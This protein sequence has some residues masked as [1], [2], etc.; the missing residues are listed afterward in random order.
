[1][2]PNAVFSSTIPGGSAVT[3]PMTAACAPSGWA[4]S[5]ASAVVGLVRRRPRRPAGP[6]R[7]RT[8]GRCRAV[9]RRRGPS[10]ATGMA[11]SLTSTPTPAEVGHLV[12]DGGHPAAGGVAQRADPGGRRQQVGDQAVQ[13]GGVRDQVGLDVQ[14][15]A[16]QHDGHAVLADRPGHDDHVAGLGV[17]HAQRDLVLDHADPGG[18][19]VAAVRLALLHHLGVAGDHLHAGRFRAAAFIEATIRVRSATGKPSS[20]MKPADRYSGVAPD[21][22]RSLTVP[23]TARSPMSPP[24][25]NSGE[26]T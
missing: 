20:R 16:G 22:A 14:L 24:G 13:R 3:W 5:A 4:R 2:P 17:G 18:V 10:V 23:L 9:R 6:R 8:S 26:T 19:D 7:P 15:T 12:E 11:S 21:T 1:M 25:K